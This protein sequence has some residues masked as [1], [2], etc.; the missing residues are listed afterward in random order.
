MGQPQ[1]VAGLS[2]TSHPTMSEITPRAG[3]V[4]SSDLVCLCH[5][6]V[7]VCVV[8]VCVH[9]PALHCEALCLDDD[10]YVTANPLVRR[11][12]LQSIRRF[13][14]EIIEPSSV[15]G[16]YQPLTMISLMMDRYVGRHFDNLYPFHRTSLLLHVANVALLSVLVYLLFRDP[17]AAALSGLFFGI[18]PVTAE[19]V[20]WVSE[21]KTLL[22]SFF[23]L[24][25]LMAYIGYVG[26]HKRRALYVCSLMAYT[27]AL[28]C[29][30]TAVA[31]PFLLVLLDSWP[32]RRRIGIRSTLLEKSPFFV[33]CLLSA[34]VTY[35]SQTRPAGVILPVECGAWRIPL[36]VCHNIAFYL[37]TILYPISLSPQYPYPRPFTLGHPQVF[38][39][40]IC[41]GCIL[42]SLAASWHRTRGVTVAFTMF[43]VALLPTMQIIGVSNEI[44][45]NRY[46]Y[47][48][49]WALVFAGAAL[50]VWLSRTTHGRH[51]FRAGISAG[52]LILLIVQ[53]VYLRSYLARWSDTDTLCAH[54]LTVAP[55]TYKIH[56]NWGLALLKENQ[57]TAALGHLQIALRLAEEEGESAGPHYNL[58]VILL[59]C[60]EARAG[61]A[62]LEK[63]VLAGGKKP[64][65]ASM[66]LA[67]V[68]ATH[69]DPNVVNPTRAIQLAEDVVSAGGKLTAVGL[70]VLAAA[71][72]ANQQ[73][74][75]AIATAK[76]ALNLAAQNDRTS[77]PGGIRARLRLYRE[78]QRYQED[79]TVAALAKA[80]QRA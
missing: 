33:V 55:E 54:I 30:P 44:A 9:W 20:A 5:L 77:P 14:T 52:I 24:W 45:A 49:S 32:L 25:S 2:P 37:R 67:W 69:P 26:G 17:W 42:V 53:A 23:A 58:G 50:L 65:R 59:Q 56:H 63:A 36:T 74:A 18:H 73:F 35:V 27:L 57:V 61:C 8:V 68:L 11:P 10:Q 79:P 75:L 15:L 16:Y 71:Y 78:G 28:L 43:M 7:V 64:D 34:V 1:M 70:D 31:L 13:L 66:T 29:K 46:L 60:G 47:L 39:G 40:V 3:A 4:D 12:S 51:L 22:A 62:H 21:R 48:P 19:T 6:L 38:L 76:K 41:T 72:A 80:F